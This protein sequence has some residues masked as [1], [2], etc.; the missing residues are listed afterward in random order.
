MCL[1]KRDDD[2]AMLVAMSIA[3]LPRFDS[4]F[5]ESILAEIRSPE[6]VQ[7]LV[8]DLVAELQSIDPAVLVLDDYHLITSVQVHSFLEYLIEHL[9]P[10]M[11]VVISSRADP[12]RPT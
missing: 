3:A 9:P 6:A 1:D 2:I 10:E 5:G 4:G 7:T 11:R 8:S 12:P